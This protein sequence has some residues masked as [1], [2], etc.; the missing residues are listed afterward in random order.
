MKDGLSAF[1]DHK[2]LSNDGSK[3]WTD[4]KWNGT[5]LIWRDTLRQSL[6]ALFI[7]GQYANLIR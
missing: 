6:E 5:N 4:L 2:V 3:Y 1:H 7:N